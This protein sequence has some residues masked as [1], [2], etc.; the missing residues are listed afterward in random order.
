MLRELMDM[1]V[2]KGQPVFEYV[3]ND[4]LISVMSDDMS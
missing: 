3:L 2:T 4:N 1:S